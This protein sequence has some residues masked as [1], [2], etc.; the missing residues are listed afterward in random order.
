MIRQGHRSGTPF[1]EQQACRFEVCRQ[2]QP[3]LCQPFESLPISFGARSLRKL[4]ASLGVLAALFWIT[5]HD[6]RPAV[7]KRTT[8]LVGT[9]R[10][11]VMRE[12]TALTFECAYCA[13]VQVTMSPLHFLQGG[14]LIR[15]PVMTSTV[16][17]NATTRRYSK[18]VKKN[19][20]ST[21]KLSI[22]QLTTE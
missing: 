17:I 8:R 10:H 12:F 18:I 4:E 3:P 14:P 22:V 6:R 9:E 11:P 21:Y 19:P 16:N 20:I 13:A 5:G 15:S 1:P 2:G 7:P